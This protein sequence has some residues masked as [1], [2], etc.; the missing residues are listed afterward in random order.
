MVQA[1]KVSGKSPREFVDIV[2]SALQ[3]RE[4]GKIA[5]ISLE[6][7]D[8]AVIFSKLGKSQI[9]FAISEA[10]GSFE[11][12]HKSEKIALAHRALRSQIEG[13][14]EKILQKCGAEIVS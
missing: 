5:S 13:K 6:G 12:K 9:L 14:V 11:A 3:E 8:I 10:D 7:S 1:I 2:Q 4:L